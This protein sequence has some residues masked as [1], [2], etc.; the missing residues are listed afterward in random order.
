MLR[1]KC[2]FL[3]K[4]YTG[5][6]CNAFL[7]VYCLC[8]LC[9]WAC[10]YVHACSVHNERIHTCA[11]CLVFLFGYVRFAITS[12][13]LSPTW[14]KWKH[15]FKSITHQRSQW[16]HKQ[17]R[18]IGEWWKAPRLT[19]AINN[20]AAVTEDSVWHKG[21]N[22]IHLALP[23]TKYNCG[24]LADACCGG[25]FTLG[26]EVSGRSGRRFVHVTKRLL[27]VCVGVCAR[28]WA[29]SQQ[30]HLCLPAATEANT[31]FA[32]H[33]HTLLTSVECVG[34]WVRVC[35][36]SVPEQPEIL[37]HLGGFCMCGH[38][39]ETCK[40]RKKQTEQRTE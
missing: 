37:H 10:A 1:L 38:A 29:Q 20:S 14:T 16:E 32:A 8:F 36:F 15:R 4:Y 34:V 5:A 40:G 39:S 9:A 26:G 22:D 6:K 7:T 17:N 3:F 12:P 18:L 11:S 21:S 13:S 23:A 27:L 35:L 25:G 19:W 28:E 33:M 2:W 24:V 31:V 30:K